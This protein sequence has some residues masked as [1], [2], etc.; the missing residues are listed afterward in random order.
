MQ[1]AIETTQSN[2]DPRL[3]R[4]RALHTSRLALEAETRALKQ[5]LRSTWH[6]PMAD[7]QR[8]LLQLRHSLTEVYCVLAL[9]RDRAHRRHEPKCWEATHGAG[10]FQPLSYSRRIAAR[11]APEL[12]LEVQS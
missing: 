8:R 9:T 11:L 5:R 2:A 3:V 4:L 10:T 7:A 12:L 1:Q 6:E